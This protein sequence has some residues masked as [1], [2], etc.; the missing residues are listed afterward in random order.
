MYI[1]RVH[2]Y[3]YMTF[4]QS[5][6]HWQ[7]LGSLKG[8][9]KMQFIQEWRNCTDTNWIDHK[10]WL[11]KIGFFLCCCPNHKLSRSLLRPSVLSDPDT[12]FPWKSVEEV[13]SHADF[14][15]RAASLHVCKYKLIHL[16]EFAN[17]NNLSHGWRH[18][19]VKCST[20]NYDCFK[21]WNFT[22]RRWPLKRS[23]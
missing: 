7:K 3:I 17:N 14:R 2:M 10:L 4:F 11:C 13:D 9:M 19:L 16:Y 18:F 6:A 23:F 8:L 12:S 1:W 5:Q 15:S 22:V 21:A 20:M